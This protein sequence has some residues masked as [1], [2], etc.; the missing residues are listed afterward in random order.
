MQPEHFNIRVYGLLINE[1]NEVL[2]SDEHRFGHAFSKFPG[3]GVELG[4]GISEALNRE[5]MEE[6]NLPVQSMDLFYV[7]DFCQLSRFDNS[8][9]ISF[10]YQVTVPDWRQVPVRKKIT[11]LTMDG[12][13][14]R[15]VPLHLLQEED[16][17]F[18][19]DKIVVQK[20]KNR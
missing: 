17:T 6:I 5:F 9:L 12:E 11:P 4:E 2:L 15:W 8:Q 16:V 10:Y 20:L 13:A 19:L 1:L 3:G 7:N 18:P 14:F